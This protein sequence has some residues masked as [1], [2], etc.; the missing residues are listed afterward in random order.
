MC[1]T[2]TVFKCYFGFPD[3]VSIFMITAGVLRFKRYLHVRVWMVL[4]R[5]EL[6]LEADSKETIIFI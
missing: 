1:N 6:A 3:D 2:L 5:F 4:N